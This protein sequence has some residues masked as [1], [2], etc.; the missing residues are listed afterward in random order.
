MSYVLKQQDYYLDAVS[1]CS[2]TQQQYA[3]RF[4]S[5]KA[6]RHCR[7]TLSNRGGQWRIVRLI[8]P[9]DIAVYD[10]LSGLHEIL[11]DILYPI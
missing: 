9:S 6:A 10:T 3:R 8:S 7:D 11:A 4:G 5:K 1:D 2:Q